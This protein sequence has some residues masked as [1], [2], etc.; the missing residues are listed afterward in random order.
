MKKL[1]RNLNPGETLTI[2]VKA[3]NGE[4]TDATIQIKFTAEHRL[5]I[6]V[7]S[8]DTCPSKRGCQVFEAVMV[9]PAE[10]P[11]NAL[12]ELLEAIAKDANFGVSVVEI[13]QDGIVKLVKP[14]DFY[15][16]FAS[17]PN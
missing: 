1:T 15:G 10:H 9:P 5:S 2:P 13:S 14:E 8:P 12:Y 17:K 4:P 6:H 11:R 3:E 16:G 7:H